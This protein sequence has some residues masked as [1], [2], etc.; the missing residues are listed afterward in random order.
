MWV[1]NRNMLKEYLMR[2]ADILLFVTRNYGRAIDDATFALVGGAAEALVWAEAS[3]V[4]VNMVLIIR[5]PTRP[6]SCSNV[7]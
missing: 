3:L 1:A 5:R 2:T 4:V 7:V 6:A